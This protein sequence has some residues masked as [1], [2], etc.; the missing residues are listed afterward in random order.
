MATSYISLG[1]QSEIYLLLQGM[2]VIYADLYF[3]GRFSSALTLTLFSFEFSYCF[4]V[5][6][7]YFP[8]FL[9]INT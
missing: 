9:W 4:V 1:R 2:A 6:K 7:Y 8:S 3:M 5:G